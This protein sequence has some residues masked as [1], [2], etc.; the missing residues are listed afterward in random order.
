MITDQDIIRLYANI[1]TIP[2]GLAESGTEGMSM[3]MFR[4]VDIKFHKNCTRHL[5]VFDRFQVIPKNCFECYKVLVTPGNVLDFFK[6]LL[7]FDRI[8]LPDDK[9]RKCF[10]EVRD[11]CSGSYKGL[12][13]CKGIAEAKEVCEIAKKAVAVNISSPVGVALQR[14]CSP[15]GRAY[16]A[17]A[18]IKPGNAIMQYRKSWQ[19][20]E[21]YFDK[22]FSIVSRQSAPDA[23]DEIHY[24]SADGSTKYTR[25]EAYCMEYYLRYAATI[26]DTS[27]L[28]MTGT[29]VPPIPNLNRPPAAHYSISR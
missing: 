22:N 4:G 27:Y 21:D 8:E 16:P 9:R 15:Y 14:G 24:V 2:H 26:G 19:I 18:Q 3:Q 1:S 12:I 20:H 10:V 13:Y 11:D 29:P 17:Y 7:V 5:E 6:L 25:R 28:A 23:S